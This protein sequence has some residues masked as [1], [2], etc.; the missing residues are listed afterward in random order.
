M[1]AKKG[2]G[3]MKEKSNVMKRSAATIE[4]MALI[5]FLL[6]AL[7]VFQK[8]ILQG[9]WGQW[10]KAGD[11]FGQGRQYDPRPFGIGGDE[12]GTLECMY[13]Y[14]DPSDP[15]SSGDWVLQPC[16]DE[17]MADSANSK[18][19]CVITCGQTTLPNAGLCY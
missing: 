1:I 18:A 2:F 10:K 12:G 14:D 19:D 4:F 15:E 7:L 8:Y 11:I 17:C 6:A 9:F 13:V 3:M 5:V 16:Y